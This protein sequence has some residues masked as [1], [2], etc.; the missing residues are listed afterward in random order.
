MTIVKG[1]VLFCEIVLKHF[2]EPF[3][4]WDDYWN[5][6]EAPQVNLC[7]K[8]MKI[9]Q[10]LLAKTNLNCDMNGLKMVCN[11]Q[12]AEKMFTI[13]KAGELG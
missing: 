13:I 1:S 4:F 7:G 2:L 8:D 9:Q 11:M 10:C 5:H 3:N 6:D 12:R